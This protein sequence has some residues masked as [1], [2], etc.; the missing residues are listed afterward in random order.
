MKSFRLWVT[1]SFLLAPLVISVLLNPGRNGSNIAN[2]SQAKL[3]VLSVCGLSLLLYGL[4]GLVQP[5]QL[6]FAFSSSPL[7][8]VRIL[9]FVFAAGLGAM[10]L[11]QVYQGLAVS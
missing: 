4:A 3:F 1:A 6:A 2:F 11:Y 10:A 5:R 9:V 8:S 7:P